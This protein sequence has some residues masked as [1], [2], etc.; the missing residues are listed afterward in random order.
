MYTT[1]VQYADSESILIPTTEIGHDIKDFFFWF[2]L[3]V[4]YERIEVDSKQTDFLTKPS[5]NRI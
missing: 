2:D 1:Y 5:L 4:L 3:D